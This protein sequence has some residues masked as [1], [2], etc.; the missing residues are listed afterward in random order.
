M[1]LSR[2]GFPERPPASPPDTCDLISS[3]RAMVVLLT[4]MP[5]TPHDVAACTTSLMSESVRSGA[6]LSRTG[7]LC[8]WPLSFFNFTARS[9]LDFKTLPSSP[10]RCALLCRFR[11]PGV[12]GL[13]MFTTM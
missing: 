10:L 9:S 7:G 11:S 1:L 13:E 6:I 8:E 2:R 4:M 5:S 12:F 3:G